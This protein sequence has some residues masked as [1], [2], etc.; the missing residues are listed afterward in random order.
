MKKRL[1][2]II[3]T[4]VILGGII[5]VL[6]YKF[7]VMREADDALETKPAFSLSD[8]Q[9]VTDFSQND[10]AASKKYIGQ[11]IQLTGIVS[12]IEKDDKG[13][14]TLVFSDSTLNIAVRSSIDSVHTLRARQVQEGDSICIKGFCK[15]YNK[16]ELLGSDIILNQCAIADSV[17]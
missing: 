5:G 7:Y 3:L 9:L 1:L 15:G 10:S 2:Y 14:I 12:A 16:D 6:T 8:K 11:P 4:L 17:K 13:N